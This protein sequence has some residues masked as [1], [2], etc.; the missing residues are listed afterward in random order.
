MKKLLIFLFLA[1]VASPALADDYS[2]LNFTKSDGTVV[3]LSVSNLQL[4]ISD[5]KLL[6]TN[7]HGSETFQ[8]A[9]LAKMYFSDAATGISSV[10]AGDA[11]VETVT[12][13][14]L[15]GVNMGSYKS[16]AEAK[17]QLRP[18]V[19]LLKSKSKTI[20]TVVQ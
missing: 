2:Y 10:G 6:A 13:Y 14:S 1:A 19:Y 18:G 15:S 8:L 5:G 3:S 7:D 17:V 16:A 12:A 11:A 9:D 20:K 4:T